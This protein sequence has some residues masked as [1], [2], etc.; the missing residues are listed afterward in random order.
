[1]SQHQRDADVRFLRAIVAKT[2]V[3]SAQVAMASALDQLEKEPLV[4]TAPRVAPPKAKA[5]EKTEDPS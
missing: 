1:M 5:K 4:E 3:G 2:Q